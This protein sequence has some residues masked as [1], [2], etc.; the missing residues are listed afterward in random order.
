MLGSGQNCSWQ[1]VVTC[2]QKPVQVHLH[3]KM[4][5]PKRICLYRA[6]L[7]CQ[8]ASGNTIFRMAVSTF[9]FKLKTQE[10]KM[11]L[12]GFNSFHCQHGVARRYLDRKIRKCTLGRIDLQKDGLK[13]GP[14]YLSNF[15]V[16]NYCARI[17]KAVSILWYLIY[18]SVQGIVDD[19][20]G[21]PFQIAVALRGLRFQIAVT[22]P[23]PNHSPEWP[24]STSKGKQPAKGGIK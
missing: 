19:I 9:F 8:P 13:H 5:Q 3:F 17:A 12:E 22:L 21:L 2:S 1:A 4:A 14:F 23:S 20:T 24:A 16:K 18:P 6:N 7:A 11:Q 10:S 15:S